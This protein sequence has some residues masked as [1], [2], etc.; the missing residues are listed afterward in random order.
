[1]NRMHLVVFQNDTRGGIHDRIPFH[2]QTIH[3]YII[4]KWTILVDLL[5]SVESSY[6]CLLVWARL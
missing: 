2:S 3:A 1:M 5:T 4:H 6:L